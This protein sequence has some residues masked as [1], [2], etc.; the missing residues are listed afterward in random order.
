MD[1]RSGGEDDIGRG[2]GTYGRWAWRLWFFLG[3]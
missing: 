2:V 3:V 1:M